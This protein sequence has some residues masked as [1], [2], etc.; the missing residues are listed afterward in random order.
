MNDDGMCLPNCRNPQVS[1]QKLLAAI[2]EDPTWGVPWNNLGVIYPP[3][4]TAAP[5]FSRSP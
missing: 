3:T 2:K 5:H 1:K 4:S